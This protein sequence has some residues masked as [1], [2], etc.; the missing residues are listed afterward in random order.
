MKRIV[1]D[2]V[3]DIASA[4]AAG[5][6]EVL[7]RGR[8]P[9]PV[10]LDRAVLLRGV[11]ADACIEGGG[12]WSL[13]LTGV[14]V[15]VQNLRIE[16]PAGNGAVLGAADTSL[17]DCRVHVS[18]L[19]LAAVGEGSRALCR[20]Q[21]LAAQTGF[22]AGGLATL[23]I[24]D[25]RIRAQHGGVVLQ[26]GVGGQVER[27]EVDCVS[28]A[29]LECSGQT[30]PV[31]RNV[32][33][34]VTQGTGLFVHQQA[35]PTLHSVSIDSPGGLGVEIT[36]GAAPEIRGLQ[37]QHCAKVGVLLHGENKAR[38]V[39][40][41]VHGGNTGVEVAASADPELRGVQVRGAGGVG[42]LVHDLARGTYVDLVCAQAG[43]TG[44]E[45]RGACVP[46]LEAVRV[47]GGASGGVWVHER[48]RAEILELEVRQVAQAAVRVGGEAA[49]Y[50]DQPRLSD[51]RGPALLLA[52]EGRMDLDGPR[53]DGCDGGALV[54]SGRSFLRWSGGEFAG[55]GR[56]P[57]LLSGRAKLLLRGWTLPD[58]AEVGS[59]VRVGVLHADQKLGLG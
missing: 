27:L 45:L 55:C 4:M 19:A 56:P 31:L 11:D 29:A 54:A 21:V 12:P 28:H 57:F 5:A 51:V 10:V 35:A 8:V 36:D 13:M 38:L 42:L 52:D 43:Q 22:A 16:N 33:L 18:A 41:Q 40:V 7:V 48:A 37:V 32:R 15:R 44:I 34:S 17:E 25:L 20:V 50:L 14:G 47:E 2:D 30:T 26:D 9:G 1:P 39:G 58:D 3:P 59:K 6:T 53:I 49:V 23:D 46:E 24:S